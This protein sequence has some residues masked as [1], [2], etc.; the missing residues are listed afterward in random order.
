MI[1][2]VN[3]III[4]DVCTTLSR[5]TLIGNLMFTFNCLRG[6]T[7][8]KALASMEKGDRSST[9]GDYFPSLDHEG[10]Q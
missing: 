6:A 8:M 7:Y 10:L 9:M 5:A 4:V 1:V 3:V 2:I